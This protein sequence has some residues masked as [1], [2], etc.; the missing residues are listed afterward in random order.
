MNIHKEKKWPEKVVQRS[1]IKGHS[2]PIGLY[3]LSCF[4]TSFS[5]LGH[6]FPILNVFFFCSVPFC[7]ASRPGF[8]LSRP[9]PACPGLSR[10]VPACPGLSRS[11]FWLPQTVPFCG[12]IFSLSCDNEGISANVSLP[13][14]RK[15]CA[16]FLACNT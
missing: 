5:V 7:L 12:K 9:V 11:G 8:R 4:R 15:N 3:I 6:P 10:P 1:F 13:R 14:G 16:C 2:F